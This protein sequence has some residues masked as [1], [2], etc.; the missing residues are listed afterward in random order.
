ME[1]K[2]RYIP[3]ILSHILRRN[4]KILGCSQRKLA[5]AFRLKKSNQVCLWEQGLAEPSITQSL[6][7]CILYETSPNALFAQYMEAV[8]EEYKAEIDE[9][10][11]QQN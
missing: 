8:R 11:S 6:L 4:R 7:L 10:F 2:G 1:S 9:F 3:N 5:R